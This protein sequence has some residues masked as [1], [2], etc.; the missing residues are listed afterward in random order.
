M[1]VIL[2][3]KAG[4]QQQMRELPHNLGEIWLDRADVDF[5]AFEVVSPL[6]EVDLLPGVIP[7]LLQLLRVLQHNTHSLMGYALRGPLEPI[8]FKLYVR[9]PGCATCIFRARIMS[10]NLRA[11]WCSEPSPCHLQYLA[12]SM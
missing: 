3:L 2:V 8:G 6:G 1:F 9:R 11:T 12:R 5:E 7:Q 4:K 10:Q